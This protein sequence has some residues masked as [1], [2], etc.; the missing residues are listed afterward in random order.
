MMNKKDWK[1]PYQFPSE[2]KEEISNKK[3]KKE[4]DISNQSFFKGGVSY[5]TPSY[6]F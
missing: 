4:F 2:K 6:L 1:N 5:M 3:E